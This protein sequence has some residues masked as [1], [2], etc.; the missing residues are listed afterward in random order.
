M[1]LYD[2]KVGKKLAEIPECCVDIKF[3]PVIDA[4]DYIRVPLYTQVQA[5]FCMKRA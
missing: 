3:G 2:D 1:T 4:K 5:F